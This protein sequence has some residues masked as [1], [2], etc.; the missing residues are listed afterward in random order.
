MIAFLLLVGAAQESRPLKADE[1]VSFALWTPGAELLRDLGDQRR[2]GLDV[3]LVHGP[4][5]GLAAALERAGDDRPLLAPYLD[6]AAPAEALK[7]FLEQV[8]ERFRAVVDG[9]LPAFLGPAPEPGRGVPAPLDGLWLVADQSWTEAPKAERRWKSGG[10]PL[11]GPVVTVSSTAYDKTWYAAL[12]LEARWVVIEGWERAQLEATSRY[13]RKHRLNEKVPAPK[14]KWTGAPKALYT[15]KYAPHE[16]GLQPVPTEEGTADL[17]QLRGIAMLSSKEAKPGKRRVL[18][19]DVD[20]SFHYFDRRSYTLTVEFLDVG[21]GSFRVEYDAADRT[22]GPEERRLKAAGER[23]FTGSGE[24]R[25]ESIDLPEA[26]FG[27]GQPGGSDFRLVLEG[28]G[29]ALR[30]V[31]LT[32][33]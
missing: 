26:L 4:A 27:N 16:Q 8:P 13:L 24:W 25:E 2:A 10:P 6:G 7:L 21:T 5:P 18:A 11:D 23:G 9:R 17:V 1:R 28:R 33:R 20:D 14:G 30:R 32:P 15:A 19:F 3:A 31:L 12:K 29:I 22:R